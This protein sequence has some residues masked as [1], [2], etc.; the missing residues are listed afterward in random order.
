MK[1][2]IL[3]IPEKSEKWFNTLFNQFQIKYK[4]LSSEAREE[5]FLARLI[6]EAMAEEGEIPKTK[7]DQF[8][9][10]YGDKI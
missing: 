5:L 6:D 4:I 10:K 7:I 2:V 3:T 9:E 8:T 1:T